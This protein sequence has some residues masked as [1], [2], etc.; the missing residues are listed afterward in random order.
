MPSVG[1][2]I[3]LKFSGEIDRACV[4]KVFFTK[5]SKAN[6]RKGVKAS[7]YLS[8]RA[9]SEIDLKESYQMPEV[10][11][12]ENGV[13]WWPSVSPGEISFSSYF[14]TSR[15][16]RKL[17]KALKKNKDAVNFVSSQMYKKINTLTDKVIKDCKVDVSERK[18]KCHS[19]GKDKKY[20][21]CVE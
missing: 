2:Q 9:E 8:L 16:S 6:E 12:L 3:D 11:K 10:L 15:N 20:F 19:F 7:I 21:K 5:F 17:L 14:L 13:H 1:Y 4:K 18:L